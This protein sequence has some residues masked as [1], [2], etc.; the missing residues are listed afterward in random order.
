MKLYTLGTS[1]GA[2]EVGRACSGNLLVVGEA[3]YLFDCGGGVEGKM[4]DLGLTIGSIRC[5]F[6]SHMHEDHAGNLSAIAKRFA[7]YIKTGERLKMFFPE[8]VG[9]AAFRAWLA[10]LHFGEND[11]LEYA[12]VREGEIYSD[13]NITV[14]AIATRHMSGGRFPSFA[15]L[16]EAEGKRMLYTGD[17]APDFSDYP[18]IVFK[19]EFDLILSELVHFDPERNL[20]T[21]AKSR[22]KRLIF[23]HISLKKAAYI[24]T[25]ADRF[26]F[27]VEVAE[28]NREYEI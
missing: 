23:T 10:A 12:L 25:V 19:E 16:I 2:T 24:E 14:S 3:S 28:D 4:T 13:E 20:D 15:Y 21:I 7:V 22:T 26:P 6:L 11:H 18:E 1:H 8:E 5:V 9:I 17:L 27:P